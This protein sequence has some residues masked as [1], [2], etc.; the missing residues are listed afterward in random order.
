MPTSKRQRAPRPSGSADARS[1][2]STKAEKAV[3][4]RSANVPTRFEQLVAERPPQAIRDDAQLENTTAIIDRLM[5][6]RR[7][8]AGQELY[9]ETLVQLA[10]AYEAAHHNVE[11]RRGIPALR[12]LLGEHALTGSDLARLL[13]VHASM[14]SKILRGERSLTVDHIKRLAERFNVRPEVFLG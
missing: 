8:T 5:A 14:G 13:G 1:R 10:Q 3:A 9:L 4:W 2:R 7:L 6:I 11:A 12:H